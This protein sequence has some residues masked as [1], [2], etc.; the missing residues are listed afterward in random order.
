MPWRPFSRCLIVAAALAVAGAPGALR[1]ENYA[2]CTARIAKDP[3]AA[4]AAAEA[5]T[6]GGPAA[7]HCRALALVALGRY[8]EAA[9]AL[10]ALAK[11]LSDADT[12]IRVA[13]RAQ[14]GL[15]W[16]NAGKTEPAIADFD[17]AL[18]LDPENAD[19]LIDRAQAH[20]TAGDYWDAIADLDKAV[21]LAPGDGLAHALRASA[22]R[23]VD[24]PELALKEAERAVALAPEDPIAVLARA[25]ARADLGDRKGAR[26]DW[27]TVVDLAPGSTAA[28]SARQALAATGG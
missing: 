21:A 10:E 26:A 25:N 4:L 18:A 11:T 8:A 27:R 3:R 13:V 24:V 22:Y 28:T 6:N 5:W 20:A 17:A 2:T 12:F 7:A 23:H 9:T 1:A 19:V 15:A 16:V 14:A